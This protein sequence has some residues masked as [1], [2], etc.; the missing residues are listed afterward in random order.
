MRGA[1]R[2]LSG[3]PKGKDYLGDLAEDGRIILKISVML[4]GVRMWNEF[5]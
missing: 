5:L 2:V 1:H 4:Q 3:S